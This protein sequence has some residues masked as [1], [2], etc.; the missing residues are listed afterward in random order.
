MNKFRYLTS[1]ELMKCFRD[2]TLF[3]PVGFSSNEQFGFMITTIDVD[4]KTGNVE[5]TLTSLYLPTNSY[6]IC[7]HVNQLE[8]LR[9][10]RFA[11]GSPCGVK[12]ENGIE[13]G[14]EI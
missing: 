1:E 5:V 7:H 8:L 9:N 12:H 6:S 3:Y 4:G 14:V 13:I 11:D 2:K 10:W